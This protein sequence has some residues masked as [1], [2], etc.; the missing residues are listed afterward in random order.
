MSAPTPKKAKT[1]LNLE[2]DDKQAH[3]DTPEKRH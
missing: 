2:I 1:R 3:H